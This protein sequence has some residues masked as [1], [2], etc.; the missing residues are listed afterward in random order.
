MSSKLLEIY[1]V[2]YKTDK[3]GD[4]AD[5]CSTLMSIL[6]YKEEKLFQKYQVFLST[7]QF[8]KNYS[9]LELKP[10]L[11]RMRGSKQWFKERKN[12]AISKAKVLVITFLTHPM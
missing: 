7:R 6:K 4:R 5:P 10:A 9:T 2:Q 1:S 8:E 12:C 11:P 3:I